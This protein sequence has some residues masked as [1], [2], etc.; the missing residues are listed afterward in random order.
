[1][2][3]EKRAIA[4]WV[5]HSAEH[6]VNPMS[7]VVTNFRLRGHHN[8]LVKERARLLG[9]AY[10]H[11]S[12]TL[13]LSTDWTDSYAEAMFALVVESLVVVFGELSVVA[14]EWAAWV[15]EA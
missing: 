4:L 15:W 13:G 5:K 6:F 10:C 7:A 14:C 9:V 11:T 12:W 3:E 8:Y 2:S 1:M